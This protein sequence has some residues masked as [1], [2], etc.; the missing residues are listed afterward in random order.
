[1]ASAGEPT[2][3]HRLVVDRFE[4]DLAVVEVDGGPALDLPRWLLPR[5]VKE[6]DVVRVRADQSAEGTLRLEARLDPEA[7]RAARGDA[8]ARL[9]RL[10]A[11]DPG[12]DVEL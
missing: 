8:A 5:E 2:A 10:R 7:T 12:G 11:R 1:V 4:G 9:R 3:E 6:G